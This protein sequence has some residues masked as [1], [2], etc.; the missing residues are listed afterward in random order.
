MAEIQTEQP[1]ALSS[2][3]AARLRNV[4]STIREKILAALST[5]TEGGTLIILKNLKSPRK[6]SNC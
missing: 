3:L 5:L 1:G 4:L 6:L 2:D